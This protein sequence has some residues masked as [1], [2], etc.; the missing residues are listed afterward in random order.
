MTL[1]H[2]PTR[3]SDF[4]QST[5]WL[6]L[7]GGGLRFS[8]GAADWAALYPQA[9]GRTR[10]MCVAQ[11]VEALAQTLRVPHVSSGFRLY[12]CAPAGRCMPSRGDHESA[13]FLSAPSGDRHLRIASCCIYCPPLLDILPM[14][15]MFLFLTP[16]VPFRGRAR[17]MESRSRRQHA[18]LA[19]GAVRPPRHRAQLGRSRHAS[20]DSPPGNRRLQSFRLADGLDRAACGWARAPRSTRCRCKWFRVGNWR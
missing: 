5:F 6:Y 1:T 19:A 7:F 3:F 10:R 17:G 15:V 18:D 12:D 13:E 11:P 20:A 14:Y 9:H 16:L 2:L 4:R 8:V